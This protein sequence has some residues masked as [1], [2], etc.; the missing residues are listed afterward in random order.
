MTQH[1]TVTID[2]VSSSIPDGAFTWK[3]IGECRLLDWVTADNYVYVAGEHGG[4]VRSIFFRKGKYWIIRDT[5]KH[6]A[7]HTADIY[8]HF[9]SGTNPCLNDAAIHEPASGLTIRSVGNGRWIEENQWVSHCYGQKEPA[10]VFRYSALLRP[11]ESVY[12]FL[13][14]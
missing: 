2:G 12:T 8:F 7:E 6:A 11:G 13:L 10:K 9:N 5:L 1:N 4:V 3:T 14:L